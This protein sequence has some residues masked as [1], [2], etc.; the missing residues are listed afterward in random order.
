MIFNSEIADSGPHLSHG[1]RHT[2][3]ARQRAVAAW[4]PCA[5]HL[6]RTLRP[7]SGRTSRQP[8]PRAPTASPTAPSPG[9]PRARRRRPDCLTDCAVAL[10]ASHAPPS[11]QPPRRPRRAAV[12]RPC[13]GEP[14][15][16]GHLPCVGAVPPPT[17]RATPP[18]CVAR[19][20]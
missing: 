14:P 16:L 4:L 5:A 17:R 8:R 7:L 20:G 10:T 19:A 11:S 2:G 6:A 9:L 15:F 18:P 12:R 3:P 13:A 1:A